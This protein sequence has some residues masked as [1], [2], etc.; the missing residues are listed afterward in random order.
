MTKMFTFVLFVNS[1]LHL[2]FLIFCLLLEKVSRFQFY[3]FWAKYFLQTKNALLLDLF[4]HNI[5]PGLHLIVSLHL[6]R[7]RASKCV[8]TSQQN[9]IK[10]LKPCVS[11]PTIWLFQLQQLSTLQKNDEI[12]YVLSTKNLRFLLLFLVSE[13]VILVKEND[14]T[15]SKGIFN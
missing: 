14:V 9:F 6:C 4:I 3:Y 1:Q 11:L 5:K 12:E 8:R 7:I 10:D 13:L 15:K 2:L